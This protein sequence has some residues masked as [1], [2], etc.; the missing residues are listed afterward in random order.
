MSMRP[1]RRIFVDL[2]ANVGSVSEAFGLDHPDYELI[3]I[4]PNIELLPV[5]HARSLT[6]PRP[7]TVIWGGRLDPQRIHRIIQVRA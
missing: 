3:A 1:L 2:G 7:I 6:L 5:I 4:E